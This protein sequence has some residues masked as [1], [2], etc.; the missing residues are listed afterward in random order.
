MDDQSAIKTTLFE[1]LG[2]EG[3]GVTCEDDAEILHDDEGWK[4]RL[5]GFMEPWKLGGTVEE[6]KT[7]LKE[8][9]AMRFGLA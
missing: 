3:C 6:A 9:G 8:M 2:E 1:I 7:T 4:L 5:C